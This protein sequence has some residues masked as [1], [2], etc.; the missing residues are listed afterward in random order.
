MA[1]EPDYWRD[2]EK[3]D[4]FFKCPMENS[5]DGGLLENGE[6]LPTGTCAKGYKGNK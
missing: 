5:C 4:L 2:N 6:I 3:S 1:P